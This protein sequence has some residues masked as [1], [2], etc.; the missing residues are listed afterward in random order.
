[1]ACA[2]YTARKRAPKSADGLMEG[3]LCTTINPRL[4]ATS[5][6]AQYAQALTCA[7]IAVI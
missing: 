2:E 7:C 3:K 4:N 5:N 1:V 6:R